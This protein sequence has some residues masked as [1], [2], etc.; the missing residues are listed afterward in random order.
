MPASCRSKQARPAP[1]PLAAVLSLHERDTTPRSV[2]QHISKFLGRLM[3]VTG[4]NVAARR[5]LRRADAQRKLA[6]QRPASEA[7]DGSEAGY[8]PLYSPQPR[9]PAFAHAGGADK[10]GHVQS[11]AFAP[12][13][14][15]GERTL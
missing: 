1:L 9:S 13:R 2:S 12:Q 11:V 7:G 3:D 10:V 4:R 5:A 15:A 6:Q 8:G 14:L